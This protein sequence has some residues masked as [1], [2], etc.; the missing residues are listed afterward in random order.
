MKNYPYQGICHYF[1]KPDMHLILHREV[2]NCLHYINKLFIYT[3]GH[4]ELAYTL[5]VRWEFDATELMVD[6]NLTSADSP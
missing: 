1:L 2:R 6:S 3:T 5:S 4:G